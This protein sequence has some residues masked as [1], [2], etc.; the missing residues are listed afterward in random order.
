MGVAGD[1]GC[2]TVPAAID[3]AD[4]REGTHVERRPD[5][6]CG[7][8]IGCLVAASVQFAD[9]DGIAAGLFY[10]HCDGALDVPAEL[11]AA[12]DAVEMAAC[13]GQLDVVVQIG[14]AR[15][16]IY[17]F[18][19][20]YAAKLQLGCSVLGGFV[21]CAIGLVDVQRALVCFVEE[22]YGHGAHVAKGVRTA[23]DGMQLAAQGVDLRPACSVGGTRPP[24]TSPEGESFRGSKSPLGEI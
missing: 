21:A 19:M 11:V 6:P 24:S 10:V 1:D 14:F 12:K 3:V 9:D 5:S 13:D 7:G 22:G 15:S 23:E 8:L 20:R 17:L 2:F 18:Q 16:T 4:A